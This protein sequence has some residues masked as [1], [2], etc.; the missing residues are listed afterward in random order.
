[1]VDLICLHCGYEGKANKGQLNIMS[2]C[3]RCGT[4]APLLTLFTETW[5]LM[6]T[7][8]EIRLGLHPVR[9]DDYVQSAP[10]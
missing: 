10:P 4:V 3:S 6:R 8:K 7:L 9:V 2:R 1:M 5:R